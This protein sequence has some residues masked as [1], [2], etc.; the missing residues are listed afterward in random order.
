MQTIKNTMFT[1][2]GRKWCHVCLPLHRSTLQHVAGEGG[3]LPAA[4]GKITA[5]Y[6]RLEAFPPL[7][8]GRLQYANTEGGRP[9]RSGHMHAVMSDRQRVDTRRAPPYLHTASNQSLEVGTA[10]DQQ[11]ITCTNFVPPPPPPPPTK[12]SD[13]TG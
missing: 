6:P 12:K 3:C 13:K 9:G 1:S 4:H 7:V 2:P 5:H 8:F 10:W 11:N